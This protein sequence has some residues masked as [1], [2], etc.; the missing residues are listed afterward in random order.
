MSNLVPIDHVDL[1]R[2]QALLDESASALAQPIGTLAETLHVHGRPGEP[3][4]VEAL[5]G[6][7]IL[8]TLRERGTIVHGAMHGVFDEK[9]NFVAGPKT[10]SDIWRVIPF[11]NYLVTAELTPEEIKTAMEE[12]YASREPRNLLGF[13]IETEGV[14]YERRI[15]AM[16]LADGRTL[17]RDKRYSIAFNTFDS[18]SGGHRFMKLRAL[19]ETPAT[20]C[21]FDPV[22][23]R[24]AMI[25]YFRRHRVVHKVGSQGY[26]AAA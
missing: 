21:T 26:R 8:E 15:T 19:L 16:R 20:R 14:G 25:D 17:E 10:I 4:G 23:T 11:E 9:N 13:E 5:I 7:A 3:S 1:S 6:A 2:A 24:D 18:R 22:Q 12:V